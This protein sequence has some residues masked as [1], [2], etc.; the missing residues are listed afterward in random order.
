MKLGIFLV[1]AAVL[2][3]TLA[4]LRPKSPKWHQKKALVNKFLEKKAGI[5]P[6]AERQTFP[7]DWAKHVEEKL[8]QNLKAD[9]EK[10][11]KKQH[12]NEQSNPVLSKLLRPISSDVIAVKPADVEKV[13]SQHFR[14][15]EQ[16]VEGYIS[17][18]GRKS[19]VSSVMKMQEVMRH[20]GEISREDGSDAS[21]MVPDFLR[22]HNAVQSGSPHEAHEGHAPMVEPE[23][24]EGHKHPSAGVL[25]GKHSEALHKGLKQSLQHT[26]EEDRMEAGH[27]VHK[28]QK[29]K[30]SVHAQPRPVG[31]AL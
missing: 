12:K 29:H 14:Q 3:C 10:T 11:K 7:V 30:E 6:P 16:K 21:E 9:E 22:G 20:V 2:S 25:S 5:E 24:E 1:M 13:S 18:Y 15:P 23:G 28:H 26:Q 4:N 27:G 19:Q 31:G 8:A 17:R